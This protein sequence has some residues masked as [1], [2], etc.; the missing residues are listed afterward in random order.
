MPFMKSLLSY[1]GKRLDI[2]AWG[3][4][5][6]A[7]L[8]LLSRLLF[9]RSVTLVALLIL[10]LGARDL[11]VPEMKAVGG[12]AETLVCGT[13]VLLLATWLALSYNPVLSPSTD[14]TTR[15]LAPAWSRWLA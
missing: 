3:L 14:D 6:F 1:K 2:V 15:H 11:L 10:A 9:S 12:A 5:L 7:L 4:I 13:L 8:F